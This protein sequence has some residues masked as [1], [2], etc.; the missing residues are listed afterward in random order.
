MIQEYGYNDGFWNISWTKKKKKMN[1][2]DQRYFMEGENV[3]GKVDWK[4]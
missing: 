3:R 2:K 1:K 4:L